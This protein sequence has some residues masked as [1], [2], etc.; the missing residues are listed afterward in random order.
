MDQI[1]KRLVETNFSELVGLTV[2][3]SIPVPERL[4]NEI[5]Q[6]E[7]QGNKNV[8]YCRISI[9]RQNRIDLQLKTP[10]WPWPLNLKLK[11]FGSVDFTQSVIVRA[12]LENNV[13]LG[14]L[15]S[16]L[17]AL[18]PGITIYNNQVSV[19]LGAFIQD[20]EP[21]KLLSL[22]KTADLKT[23]AGKLILNVKIQ[24]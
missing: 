15:G 13:L 18:P 1:F 19:D 6:R 16:L 11:L 7:L 24:N 3:A 12:F 2:D 14:K 8:T 23:D 5:I 4:V 21:K 10:L 22:V 20:P 9:E 17:K